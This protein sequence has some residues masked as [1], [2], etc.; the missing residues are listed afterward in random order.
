MRTA[1]CANYGKSTISYR[2]RVIKY[3]MPGISIKYATNTFSVL[4]KFKIMARL[5]QIHLFFFSANKFQFFVIDQI[6]QISNEIFHFDFCFVCAYELVWCWRMLFLSFFFVHSIKTN[7]N[8]N[9]RQVKKINAWMGLRIIF[10]NSALVW[11][12]CAY[13]V[14]MMI[15]FDEMFDVKIYHIRIWTFLF[16]FMCLKLKIEAKIDE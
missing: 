2:F 4:I 6:E 1:M 3:S 14:G 8:E 9:K 11:T 16:G 5:K 10:V 13:L 15:T 12:V 7:N